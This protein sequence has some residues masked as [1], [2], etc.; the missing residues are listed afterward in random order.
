MLSIEVHIQALALYNEISIS[1][2]L[3]AETLQELTQ[4]LREVQRAREKPAKAFVF[5]LSRLEGIDSTGIGTLINIHRNMA[6]VYVHSQS[7][8]VQEVLKKVGVSSIFKVYVD[9][10]EFFRDDSF[11][12]L[13]L[14]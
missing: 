7:S 11:V 2:Y 6:P 5:D 8:F 3:H 9:R 4:K 10:D 1:G 13:L 12:R 14:N